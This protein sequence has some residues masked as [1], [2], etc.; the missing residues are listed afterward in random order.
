M[1]LTNKI[2]KLI[3]QNYSHL[4]YQQ[5]YYIKIYLF[6]SKLQNIRA[7]TKYGLGYSF[8]DHNLRFVTAEKQPEKAGFVTM[9]TVQPKKVKPVLFIDHE[10]QVVSLL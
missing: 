2:S 3:Q 10:I 1:I 9:I 8:I 6:L 5:K 4:K 7:D